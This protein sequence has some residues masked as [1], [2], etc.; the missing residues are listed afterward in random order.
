MTTFEAVRLILV[1]VAA[2][3]VIGVEIQ[4]QVSPALN[5]RLS[6]PAVVSVLVAMLIAG[7]V[8]NIGLLLDNAATQDVGMVVMLVVV[9]ALVVVPTRLQSRR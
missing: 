8:F 6:T 4:K 7:L 5:R 3:F 1:D 9:G 2:V